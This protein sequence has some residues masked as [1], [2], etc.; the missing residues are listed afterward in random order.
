MTHLEQY[1][2]SKNDMELNENSESEEEEEEVDIQKLG[3]YVLKAAKVIEV[4]GEAHK[5]LQVENYEQSVDLENNAALIAIMKT[6]TKELVTENS[7]IYQQLHII[8]DT[9]KKTG[10]VGKTFNSML[11]N[12]GKS[13]TDEEKNKVKW[14]KKLNA[15]SAI[16]EYLNFSNKKII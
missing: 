8:G 6:R 13:L 11:T 10:P 5:T 7:T 3:Q 2:T 12:F 15:E 4:M 1:K 14:N 16:K 9:L